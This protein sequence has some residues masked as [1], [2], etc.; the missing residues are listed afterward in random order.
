METTNRLAMPLLQSGQAAKE[1]AHN[2]ALLIA[3]LLVG[4]AV[5][6]PPRN[7]PPSSP[8]VGQA[9]IIGASPSGMWAG[10]GGQVAGYTS[11]GWRYVAPPDGLSLLV[12]STGT[13]AVRR[14]GAWDVG[15][16]RAASIK[17]GG[18]Q[19]VGAQFSAI[20]AP[21]GGATVDTEARTA[22][23]SVLAAL[24]SHGLVAT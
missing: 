17:V 1:V 2:E 13:F 9:W 4:G 21:A 3:D 12:R 24:R 15:E 8:A 16:V 7:A 23:A 10:K 18:A 22:L 19:V 11:A 5:E 14:E 20:A 6:E